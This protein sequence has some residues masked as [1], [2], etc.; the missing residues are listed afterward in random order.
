MIIDDV[1]VVRHVDVK[2]PKAVRYA[3][4]NNPEGCNLSIKRVFLLL[5]SRPIM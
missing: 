2:E 1:V 3:W 4:A 5:H